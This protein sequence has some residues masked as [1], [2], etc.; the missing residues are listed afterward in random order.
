MKGKGIENVKVT[1]ELDS[2]LLKRIQALAEDE[3]RSF[4]DEAAYLLEKGISVSEAETEQK[5]C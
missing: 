3:K 5:L 2:N 4:K 1:F